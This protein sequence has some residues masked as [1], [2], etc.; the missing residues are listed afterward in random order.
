MHHLRKLLL[1]LAVAG[2]ILS[3]TVSGEDTN[4]Q[5]QYAEANLSHFELDSQPNASEQIEW[6]AVGERTDWGYPAIAADNQDADEL[7][8]VANA[9]SHPAMAST[10]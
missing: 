1:A 6:S 3:G 5:G 4:K 7:F 2:I 8:G 9:S 10:K